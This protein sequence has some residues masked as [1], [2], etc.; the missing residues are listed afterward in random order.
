MSSPFPT[1][2][3]SVR[4][5]RRLFLTPTGDLPEVDS[6]PSPNRFTDVDDLA[7]PSTVSGLS[8]L[9]Q[10][11]FSNNQGLSTPIE[12]QPPFTIFRDPTPEQTTFTHTSATTA[13]EA[14]RPELLPPS[15]GPFQVDDYVPSKHIDPDYPPPPALSPYMSYEQRATEVHDYGSNTLVMA[16]RV[17][18]HMDLT[19]KEFVD[20]MMTARARQNDYS[21]GYAE[22][23]STIQ[24]GD[25]AQ[26]VSSTSADV[27]T[28]SEE[29]WELIADQ[30]ELVALSNWMLYRRKQRGS[31][32]R[33]LIDPRSPSTTA[34]DKRRAS[35]T[36]SDDHDE[37]RYFKALRVTK[38]STIHRNTPCPTT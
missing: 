5:I 27:K 3:R 19:I 36:E 37:G 33:A 15:R 16:K 4:P 13:A 31:H 21:H 35:D 6:T 12:E 29:C 7:A 26:L 2:A 24:V 10:V 8:S 17:I 30:K 25:R 32:S 34:P 14:R 22:I 38:T 18:D 28:L 9:E 20:D 23:P 1:P 11:D